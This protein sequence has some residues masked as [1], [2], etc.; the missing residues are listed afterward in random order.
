MFELSLRKKAYTFSHSLMGIIV[1]SHLTFNYLSQP[2]MTWEIIYFTYCANAK[3][4]HKAEGYEIKIP[5]LL[6]T[7]RAVKGGWRT[8]GEIQDLAHE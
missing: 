3:G 6:H 5:Q 1:P 2:S 7:C 8:G 4:D